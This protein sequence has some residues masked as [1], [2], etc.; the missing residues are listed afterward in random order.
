MEEFL[1]T[2]QMQ[3]W[4]G[5]LWELFNSETK[6]CSSVEGGVCLENAEY[7][8]TL[9]AWLVALLTYPHHIKSVPL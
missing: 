7:T 2:V 4:R 8:I 5:D 6:K 1:A 9:N 3:D